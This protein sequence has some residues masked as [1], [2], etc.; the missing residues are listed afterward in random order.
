MTIYEEVFMLS[1]LISKSDNDGNIDLNENGIW[2]Q[3]LL[4]ADTSIHVD[5]L[6]TL[7]DKKILTYEEIGDD[8]FKPIIICSITNNT[9]EYLK[10]LINLCSDTNTSKDNQIEQLNSRITEVLTFNPRKLSAEIKEAQTAIEATRTHIAVNPI[11]TPLSQ[12]L[13]QIEKHFLSLSRVADNYEDIYKNIIL[14]VREEGK[15]GIRQTVKWAIIGIV[16]STILSSIISW[17]SK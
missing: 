12:P 17:L 3:F 14:P 9:T 13:S 8:G 16:A 1:T 15:S 10:T 5:Y 2:T 7:N 4:N 11:L 6:F